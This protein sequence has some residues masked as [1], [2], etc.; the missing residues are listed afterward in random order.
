MTAFDC[1]LLGQ[2][3]PKMI[4]TLMYILRCLSYYPGKFTPV[5]VK[6]LL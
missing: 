3:D 4:A 5:V 1:E 2:N 6:W